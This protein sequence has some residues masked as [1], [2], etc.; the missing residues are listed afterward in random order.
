MSRYYF[1]LHNHVEHMDEEGTEMPNLQAA[2]AHATDC[3][4]D[5]MAHDVRE[6]DACLSDRIDVN[7]AA[8]EQVLSVRFGDVVNIRA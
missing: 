7:D 5:E 3:A 6:G 2:E 1:N 8:G 4:R